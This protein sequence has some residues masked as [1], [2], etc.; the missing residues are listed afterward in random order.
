MV[1][2]PQY[3]LMSRSAVE[4]EWDIINYLSLIKRLLKK[5]KSSLTGEAAVKVGIAVEPIELR[6]DY[7]SFTYKQK[8][9]TQTF[10][11][12]A[13]ERQCMSKFFGFIRRCF[14]FWNQRRNAWLDSLQKVICLHC[15]VIM[16]LNLKK[17]DRKWEIWCFCWCFCSIWNQ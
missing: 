8:N 2:T 13:W 1:C 3:T 17:T 11:F 6:V 9:H 10:H 4:R 7:N 16:L 12:S 5:R 15:S 14:F